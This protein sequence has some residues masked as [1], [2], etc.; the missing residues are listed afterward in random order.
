MKLNMVYHTKALVSSQVVARWTA[1]SVGVDF[2]G[3]FVSTGRR[4]CRHRS[5]WID[6]GSSGTWLQFAFSL[7]IAHALALGARRFRAETGWLACV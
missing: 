1:A 4:Q 6:G 3:T 5:E 2:A 7:A